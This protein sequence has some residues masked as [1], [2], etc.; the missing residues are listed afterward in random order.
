ML[1]LKVATD[2]ESILAKMREDHCEHILE[3]LDQ[4]KLKIDSHN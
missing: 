3:S 2:R 4:V 1:I